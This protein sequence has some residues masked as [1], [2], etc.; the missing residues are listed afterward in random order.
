M[1][2]SCA[3]ITKDARPR[4]TRLRPRSDRADF[5][6]TETERFP[7][8]ERDA[9]LVEAGRETDGIRKVQAEDR[10]RFRRR[11]KRAQERPQRRRGART[12]SAR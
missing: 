9:V 2:A 11:L 10:R 3:G 4:I 6:E 1:S 5:D 8:R 12:L 7:C